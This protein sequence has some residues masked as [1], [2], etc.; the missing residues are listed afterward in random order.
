MS[1]RSAS[2][3]IEIDISGHRLIETAARLR[4][5]VPEVA[6]QAVDEIETEVPQFVRPEDPR[7]AEVL[8]HVVEWIIGHFVELMA[9]PEAPSAE[10]LEFLYEVGKGEAREG[11]GT[12]PFQTALRIG[13]GVAVNRLNAE[14]EA[15][16]II[17]TPSTMAQ[18]TQA[19]FNYHERLTEAVAEGHADHMA[20]SRGEERWR[21][22]EHL[23]DLLVMP[24]PSAEAIRVV[25]K[26][27]RW[28][29][30]AT[31]AA[32]AVE[33]AGADDAASPALPAEV[34]SGMQREDPCMI[35]PDPEGPGRRAMLRAGLSGWR[36]AVGP[37]VAVTEVATSLRWAR[38]ALSLAERGMIP[39]AR[40]V[41]AT[42]HLPLLMITQD[43]DLMGIAIA[44]RLTPLLTLPV[45][46][47]LRLAETF[48]ACLA[49]NF[50]A[51]EVAD[52][53]G[54]H[55]QTVRYR[56]RKLE[57]TFGLGIHD[58]DRRFEYLVTL[59]AWLAMHGPGA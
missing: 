2:R 57:Q 5:F 43:E 24:V 28:P 14:S 11:R 48:Y 4:K 53:L 39:A 34:L 51:T 40:P 15:M 36:A 25:A 50:N 41:F 33:R 13:A 38:Q 19:L 7:Y 6:R 1:S 9:D 44:T 42:D 46:S 37:A 52:R 31:V 56:I 49:C 45:T 17:S 10:L 16:G 30:P 35:I 32:V 23:V 29:L 20:K 27:A 22:R 8:G 59:R 26:K 47:R 18:I 55:A 3:P 58:I 21:H 54:V 12:E